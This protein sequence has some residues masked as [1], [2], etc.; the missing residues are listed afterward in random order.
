[1]KI[2]IFYILEVLPFPPAYF[3]YY[4]LYKS[5]FKKITTNEKHIAY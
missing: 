2:R 5:K 3:F 4:K 1:M